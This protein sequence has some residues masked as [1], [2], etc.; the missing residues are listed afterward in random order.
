MYCCFTLS[1][2][3]FVPPTFLG[4]Q[5]ESYYKGGPHSTLHFR[6]RLCW[7][8]HPAGRVEIEGTLRR[9]C[10]RKGQRKQ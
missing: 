9:D 7:V 6:D 10:P 5:D 4:A 1:N 3:S 8:S 2:S